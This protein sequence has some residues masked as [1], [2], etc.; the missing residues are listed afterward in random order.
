M[1][2]SLSS[3]M[4]FLEDSDNAKLTK[5]MLAFCGAMSLV[6]SPYASN[7]S[8]AT[9]QAILEEIPNIHS[10]LEAFSVNSVTESLAEFRFFV[11]FF[12]INWSEDTVKKVF[13]DTIKYGEIS[14]SVDPNQENMVS[15]IFIIIIVECMVQISFCLSCSCSFCLQE[16]Q[17]YTLASRNCL[18][19]S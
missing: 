16:L 18:Q 7:V 13:K 10:S 3:L 12:Q 17:P 19:G 5:D 9:I 15:Y 14:V 2:D 1:S 11:L 6:H 8:S 4:L